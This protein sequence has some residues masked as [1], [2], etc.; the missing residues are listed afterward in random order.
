MSAHADWTVRI[1]RIGLVAVLVLLVGC[2]SDPDP[3]KSTGPS[4]E[5]CAKQRD[6]LV[7][8]VRARLQRATDKVMADLNSLH[9]DA[10]AQVD[11]VFDEA[12]ADACMEGSAEL[13]A[14]LDRG[15][16][17]G[18]GEQF[19]RRTNRAFQRW[20]EAMGSPDA[21]ISYPPDPCPDLRRK[22]RV[23]YR[24]IRAPEPGGVRV[25]LELVLQNGSS[26]FDYVSHGGRVRATHVRPNDRTRTFVW[27]GSSG[28]IDDARVRRT[29]TH[30]VDL[31]PLTT[32]GLHLFP[33]GR[34]QVLQFY[35]SWGLC[36]VKVTR[37]P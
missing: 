10:L 20:A 31:V 34:V 8:E 7:E 36:P 30:P 19:V 14:L 32:A 26:K 23:S 28:D 29:S 18:V 9:F 17:I 13:D 12:A 11:Q 27:G 2:G 22:V 24:V 5:E 4:S 15:D 21:R 6:R 3:G 1:R 35:A 37:S 25:S 33:E 16:R